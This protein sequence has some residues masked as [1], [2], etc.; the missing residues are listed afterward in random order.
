MTGAP[1]MQTAAPGMN[2]MAG[3]SQIGPG[4]PTQHQGH[5]YMNQLSNAQMRQQPQFHPQHMLAMQQQ[6]QQPGQPQPMQ[7]QQQQTAALVAQLQ[8][9]MSTGLGGPP[10][11]PPAQ[12]N[13]Y[14]Q[15]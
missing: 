5:S 14:N 15:Y 7:Q 1:G 4:A 6:Q 11:G 10:Q 3:Y 8:R 2:G 13:T 9:R 12:F